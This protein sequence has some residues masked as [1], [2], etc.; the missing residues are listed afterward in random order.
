MHWRDA[1]AGA[2]VG[3]SASAAAILALLQ[4][5]VQRELATPELIHAPM[6]ERELEDQHL[7]QE[8]KLLLRDY[9][10]HP[11]LEFSG[12]TSTVWSGF[13]AVLP[14]A[15]SPGAIEELT[16]E[17]GGTVSL[18]WCEEPVGVGS[19][20]KRI[21]L[22]L[23]GLNNDSRTSFI[24]TTMQHLRGYGFHA[25]ALNYRGTGGLELKSPRLGCADSWRD[26]APVVAHLQRSHPGALIFGI[27]FSMGGGIL[28][29]HLGEEGARAGFKAAVTIAAPVDFIAVASS[30]E[31]S[32]RKR[33]MN[34]L[35]VNGIKFLMLHGVMKSPFAGMLDVGKL[36]RARSLRQFDEASV[37]RMHGYKDAEDYYNQ[38][39]ALPKLRNV[40][41]PTL[42][43]HA[44]DDPVV[45][46]KTLPI[47]ELRQNPRIYVAIT[48]RGGHIGWGSG[49]LGAAAW[50]DNMAAD[51]MQA[52][53]LRSRL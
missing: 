53:A 18:H 20:E 41:V 35:M 33:W 10:P 5:Y 12:Y 37:C 28:L 51:F 24:Q 8:V 40:A 2:A 44:A 32:V 3:A 15:I 22:V 25:V 34:F 19:R 42:I 50:T 23:P 4:R 46:V 48:R 16:L 9:W 47:E 13:W 43:V 36:W 6:E 29:R 7:L 49:G 11:I 1:A 27:G 14:S 21:A 30:L 39:S 26:I 52:C 17:D 31:S 38:S 45:S